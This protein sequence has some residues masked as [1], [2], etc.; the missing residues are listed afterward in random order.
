MVGM[1]AKKPILGYVFQVKVCVIHKRLVYLQPIIGSKSLDD[2]SIRKSNLVVVRWTGSRHWLF[3]RESG[4]GHHYHWHPCSFAD[5]QD[6][7]VVPVAIR[8]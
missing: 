7:L 1:Q 5:I 4:D 8:R 3:C 2:E 6:W